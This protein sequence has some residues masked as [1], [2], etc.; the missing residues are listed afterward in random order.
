MVDAATV[1]I[2]PPAEPAARGETAAPAPPAV[3]ELLVT[4]SRR[5][6]RL[7]LLPAGVSVLSG[8]QLNASNDFDIRDTAGQL[9][10]VTMTNL[11]PGRDKLSI[12][13][14]SDG[15][16]TGRARS[17]VSTYLDDTPINYNAP[18]PD[19]R[20]TDVQ[21]VE[22]IRGPQGALYGSGAL[23]GVYRIVTSKPDAGRYSA[24]LSATE[25]WTHGGAPSQ[26]VDGVINA[27][28]IPDR[29]ALRVV[30]Y[31]DLQGGY[32]D[33]V[34]LRLSDVDTTLRAGARVAL[35]VGVNDNWQV[36]V[37]SAVQRLH[38]KDTQYTNAG[39]GLAARLRANRVR[40][41]HNNDF[42]E[43]QVS[44]HGDLGWATLNASSAYVSH[45]FASEYDA[46]GA[47]SLFGR[48]QDLGVY[49]ERARIHRVVEDIVLTSAG[50]G[51]LHWLVGVYGASSRDRTPSFLFVSSPGKPL[52]LVY[53]EARRD[54]VKDLALYGDAS[55]TFAP[56]WTASAG[57]RASQT[58][59]D[60]ASD[61]RVELPNFSR[62][63]GAAHR[64]TS[65]S[66]KLSLEHE[67]ASGDILYGLISDGERAG[68][69]NTT[70]FAPVRASRLTFAPDRL[71]NYEVGAKGRFLD[72]RLS[73]RTAA[74]FDVWRNVQSDQYRPS[75]LAY[76]ANIGDANIAG[77]EA[78]FAY[79]VGFGLSLQGNALYNQPRFTRIN[80]DFAPVLAAGLP[81]SPRASAGILARY[82]RPLAGGWSL[83][84]IGQAAY[85]GASRLT[86]A[87]ST[88]TDTAAYIDARLSAE[89]LVRRWSAGVFIS[90]PANAAGNTFA[91]GNPFTFGQV[92]QVTP[93]RPRT[94]GLRLTSAF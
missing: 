19:L 33:D 40:E 17:T 21:R 58:T 14:L 32:L 68:G 64:F 84:L 65:L 1:R 91:Y 5:P 66:P 83:R 27:P 3:A 31:Y 61:I 94:V 85:I 6:E 38:S 9:V 30:A 93:Q 4:A 7:D 86:F 42:G 55:W 8:A 57:A 44:V 25:A 89:V 23:A 75:G 48:G 20:L 74:F 50:Q 16:F 49:S 71:T 59:S 43:G 28:L 72:G 88:A 54:R 2:Q 87:P 35:R 29:A 24:S 78:E 67:F 82:D 62:S 53:E 22:T 18:D 37:S 36:D 10:G 77:I 52:A 76:T 26:E 45:D 60:T 47:P 80:P 11:G 46:G 90:N 70:G 39:R 12:R 34:K 13:G 73:V 41:A 56:G 51:P 79:D 63:V 15:A 81:G 92:H 69:A